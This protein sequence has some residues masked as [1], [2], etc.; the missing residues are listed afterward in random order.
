[1]ARSTGKAGSKALCQLATGLSAAFLARMRGGCV[2]DA[3][4]WQLVS[5]GT[6]PAT[7]PL[8]AATWNTGQMPS[9]PEP[10]IARA[11]RWC[12]QRVPDNARDQ[13]RVDAISGCRHLTILVYRPPWC[14]GIGSGW[15]R[16]PIARLRYAQATMDVVLARPSP[17]LS[18]P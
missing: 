15:T 16:F 9:V 11:R 4:V 5:A 12:E 13:I 7:P 18:P 2:K 6:G 10:G 8:S 3:V 14:P 17:A 1:L